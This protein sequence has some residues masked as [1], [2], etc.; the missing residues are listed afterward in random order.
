MDLEQKIAELKETLAE[1]KETAGQDTIQ[2]LAVDDFLPFAEVV[3]EALI[4]AAQMQ[5]QVEQAKNHP[6]FG[7]LIRSL[8]V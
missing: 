3:V 1:L 6:V 5:A 4:G 8:G 2:Y 7:G